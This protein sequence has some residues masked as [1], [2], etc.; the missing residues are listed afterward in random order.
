MIAFTRILSGL[1]LLAAAGAASAANV[2][3]TAKS[4]FTF[5]PSNVTINVGDT[6]TFKNGGGLHNVVSNSTGNVF[7]CANG[8]Q[9]AGGNGAPSDDPWQ[10]VV[11]FSNPGTVQFFCELHGA[12]GQ[13]MAGTITVN[14]TAPGFT[15]GPALSGN[16]Y[17]PAQNG[18]G[19]QFE[20][21]KDP[22]GF[23]TVFWFVFDNNGNQAWISG[24][25]QID[26]NKLVVS[27]ARRL[28][29]KFPPNFNTDEAVG[30]PW[31][32]LSF[33]FSDCT[34]GHVDWTST[35]ASF[36]ATGGMD[37]ER[38]TQVAGTTCP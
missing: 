21:L 26:G 11:T 7:R 30:T 29:A 27:A 2:I 5:S 22:A 14:G 18:H 10:A 13:G 23:A 36:T 35:D 34:H 24:A 9:G 15:L 3:V 6:V 1:A 8:C 16:W 20:V 19:F 12:A 25:G 37:I 4:N 32:T 33:T 31:G 38:L 17:N 28:G